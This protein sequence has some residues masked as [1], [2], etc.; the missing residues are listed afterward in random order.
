MHTC[1]P[2]IGGRGKSV[3]K[4]QPH[5][6]SRIP[7]KRE[8]RMMMELNGEHFP[9]MYKVPASLPSTTNKIS[10]QVPGIWS[11]L[12]EK[13]TW[14]H[15]CSH[16][17]GFLCTDVRGCS[18]ERLEQESSLSG[19]SNWPNAR[20]MSR[21]HPSPQTLYK[22]EVNSHWVRTGKLS[23]PDG[24]SFS[25]TDKNKTL[26]PLWESENFTDPAFHCTEIH[27]H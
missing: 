13:R 22:T 11:V 19:R 3:G 17:L 6:L 15:I 24:P 16:S 9:A 25:K 8:D 18:W 7:S 20:V 14:H 23:Y 2:C 1:N 10:D 4:R 5:L 12:V 26:S 27:H 21:K